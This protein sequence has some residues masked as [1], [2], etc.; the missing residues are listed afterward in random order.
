MKSCSVIFFMWT[1]SVIICSSQ[2]TY[3]N[4]VKSFLNNTLEHFKSYVNPSEEQILEIDKKLLVLILPKKDTNYFTTQPGKNTL[5]PTIWNNSIIRSA[6][7]MKQE[8]PEEKTWNINL[9]GIPYKITIKNPHKSG[10][11]P[12]YLRLQLK[13]TDRKEYFDASFNYN[14]KIWTFSDRWTWYW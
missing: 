8:D 7:D 11:K 9:N 12:D 1:S 10:E 14:N 6:L 13:K 4:C 2:N 3:S 5:K